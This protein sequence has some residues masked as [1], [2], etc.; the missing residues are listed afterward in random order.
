MA[1][2]A[3]SSIP[4]LEPFAHAMTPK[5]AALIAIFSGLHDI[6]PDGDDFDIRMIMW[7]DYVRHKVGSAQAGS[8]R[9]GSAVRFVA[10]TT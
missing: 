9:A 4:V 7:A 8:A 2:W 1:R 10:H 3:D 6:E 5:Q